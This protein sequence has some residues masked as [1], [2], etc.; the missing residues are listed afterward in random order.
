M[1]VYWLIEQIGSTF[2]AHKYLW[3]DMD[4]MGLTPAAVGVWLNANN[5]HQVYVLTQCSYHL[6]KTFDLHGKE[7][8]HTNFWLHDLGFVDQLI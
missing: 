7:E 6:H 5:L 1:W 2:I 3:A 4:S 8:L